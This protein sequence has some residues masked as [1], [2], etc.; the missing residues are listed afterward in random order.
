MA[1]P[2][3]KSCSSSCCSESYTRPKP[4]FVKT[5]RVCHPMSTED[6]KMPRTEYDEIFR[7]IYDQHALSMDYDL[8]TIQENYPSDD[9]D[10]S[11][12]TSDSDCTESG[13]TCQRIPTMQ[14]KT[15]TKICDNS[16]CPSGYS[17]ITPKENAPF[18]CFK[19]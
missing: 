9:S 2:K 4:E 14:G 6:G 16:D 8:V 12:C 19:T 10:D 13:F 3:K 7:K 5:D 17:C 1:K 18:Y 15:C 11:D